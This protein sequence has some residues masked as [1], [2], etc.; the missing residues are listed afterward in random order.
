MASAIDLLSIYVGL[1]LMVL[2]TYVLT[3]FLRK[4]GGRTRR[5]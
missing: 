3:G 5:R 1:E 2:C 4:S